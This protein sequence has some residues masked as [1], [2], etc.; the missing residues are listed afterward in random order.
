MGLP[1]FD[2]VR[3]AMFVALLAGVHMFGFILWRKRFVKRA[4]LKETESA[5]APLPAGPKLRKAIA[6][7]VIQQAILLGLTV[8]LLDGGFTFRV[9]LIAALGHWG[10]IALILVRRAARPTKLDIGVINFGLLI[11]WVLT[12]CLTVPVLAILALW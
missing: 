5:Y 12:A 11:F 8:S 10:G 4:M 6:S 9:I 3:A 2:V 1:K 7:A